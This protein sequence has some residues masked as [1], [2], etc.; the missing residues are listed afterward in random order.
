M[1]GKIIRVHLKGFS[2]KVP[3]ILGGVSRE[4]PA[5]FPGRIALENLGRTL[6]ENPRRTVAVRVSGGIPQR[7]P[8]GFSMGILGQI[9]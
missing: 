5:E 9:T 8:E 2:L 4:T 7:I 1:S 6:A 3:E